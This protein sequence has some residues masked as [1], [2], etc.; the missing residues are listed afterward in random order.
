MDSQK[1]KFFMFWIITI[2]LT[3]LYFLD[4]Y[5]VKDKISRYKSDITSIE[6]QLFA[7]DIIMEKINIGRIKGKVTNLNF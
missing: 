5:Q 4:R 1:I 6:T 2:S 3:V 7:N